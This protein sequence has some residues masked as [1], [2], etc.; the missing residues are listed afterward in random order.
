MKKITIIALCLTALFAV[1]ACKTQTSKVPDGITKGQVDSVSTAIGVYF[2]DMIK[3]SNL[4][5]VNYAVIYQT[6]KKVRD[7]KDVGITPM[8]VG[9]IINSYMTKKMMSANEQSLKKGAEFLAKNK[10]KAGVVELPSGLQ[11]K[12]IEEGTG[13]YPQ[14]VDT[15]T[16]HY[17]GTLID[18]TKFDSS[19]D[20]GEPYTTPLNGVIQGWI[21]GFQH[22]KEGTKAFLYIPSDLGY[23]ERQMSAEL[24]PNSTLI[25]E[26]ELIKVTKA[27]NQ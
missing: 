2:A 19:F 27:Q 20:R 8:Q 23:G 5:E 18:G 26:V 7:G 14:A 13:I 10:T 6:M 22:F 15:V 16:V 17:T 11:Y 24:V 4:D 9:E 1:Q 25:F 3:Q 21:E 12:I